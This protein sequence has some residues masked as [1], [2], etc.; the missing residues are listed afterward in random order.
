M[1]N[2]NTFY[3]KILKDNLI[4]HFFTQVVKLHF[5]KHLPTMIDFWETVLFGKAIYKGNPILK[6]IDLH[7]IEA[8]KPE[9]FKRWIAVW[10]ETVNELFKGENAKQAIAKAK[11][12]GKL[13]E[14][15][16]EHS[17]KK[18]FIL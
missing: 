2:G 18:G 11:Q 9:H 16:I 1:K 8:L 17:A 10:K 15:K 6:H 7:R 14:I 13:M 3:S 12:M 4:G 5:E